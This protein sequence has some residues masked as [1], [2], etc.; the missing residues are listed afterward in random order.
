MKS[1]SRWRCGISL[2][3][4][5]IILLVLGIISAALAPSLLRKVRKAKV[6]RARADVCAVRDAIVLM[7]ADVG[8][9]AFLRDGSADPGDWEYVSLAVG[10]GDIPEL[11]PDG[12]AQW[13]QP[14][15]FGTV[16][17]LGYHILSNKPGNDPAKAYEDWKGAYMTPPIRPDPWGNRYMVNIG[18]LAPGSVYDTVVISAGPDEEID[19]EFSLDGFVS[20]D[21]DIVCLVSGGEVTE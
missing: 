11:G 4:V 21:D 10:D 19:S 14:V 2:I 1:S 13:T 6:Q 12:S 5:T 8:P 3:E 17:F 15:N 18:A 7:L 20:G 9:S 16:D